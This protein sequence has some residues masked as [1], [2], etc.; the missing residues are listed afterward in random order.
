MKPQGVR[1]DE[2]AEAEQ[3]VGNDVKRDEETIVAA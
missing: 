3:R 1:D 2:R